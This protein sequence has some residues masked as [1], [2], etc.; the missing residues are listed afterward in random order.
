MDLVFKLFW[1]VL[2]VGSVI[3]LTQSWSRVQRRI[4]ADPTLEEGY[5]RLFRGFLIWTNLPWVLMG[6][7]ILTGHA[8][9]MFD[10]VRPSATNTYVMAWYWAMGGLLALGSWWMLFGGGAEMLET[11][12]GLYMVPMWKAPGLKR[13]WIGMLVFVIIG[14]LF[15]G[16]ATPST[17]LRIQP[18]MDQWFPLL[19][20][21][22][23]VGMW[24][25]VSFLLAAISG[26]RT[27]AHLYPAR[28]TF[29]GKHYFFRSGNLNGVRYGGCL[30]LGADRA[31]LSMSVL[32]MFRMGHPPIFIPWSD[33]QAQAGRDWGF[34]VINLSC[35]QVPG[36]TIRLRRKDA[37]AL[38]KD[39]GSPVSVAVG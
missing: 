14:A 39:A 37:E 30:T 20:P 32:F 29:S 35:K 24:L 38:F 28:G 27:L 13:F 19:F 34:S 2:I 36:I 15:Q 12:P 26:W 8:A 23:F 10:F 5:R 7:V 33:V 17:H 16:F 4:Q 11:H 25:L 3:N 31:G 22:F 18:F 21:F 9:S 1:I 6:V